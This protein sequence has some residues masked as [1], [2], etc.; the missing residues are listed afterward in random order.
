MNQVQ[1]CIHDVDI[2]EEWYLKFRANNYTKGSFALWY[3]FLL[4]DR[5]TKF[6][7]GRPHYTENVPY[8]AY[9]EDFI[10]ALELLP[11]FELKEEF[12]FS[13]ESISL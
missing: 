7:T 12:I 10:Y 6:I 11:T 5:N 13:N 8:I 9:S 3:P 2:R 4:I 1:L